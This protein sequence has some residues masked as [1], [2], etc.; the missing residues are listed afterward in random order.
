LGV[1]DADRM[2]RFAAVRLEDEAGH[3]QEIAA[4]DILEETPVE[5]SPRSEVPSI[6]PLS[7]DAVPAPQESTFKITVS[8]KRRLRAVVLWAMCLSLT[9]LAVAAL[10][11]TRSSPSSEPS[12]AAAAA[13][14]AAATPS[15]GEN[16]PTPSESPVAPSSGSSAAWVT[17]SQ[18]VASRSGT[19]TLTGAGLPL[20]IDGKRMTATSAIVSC[21]PH[22]IR[23]G[24]NKLRQVVVPCGATV[25]LDRAGTPTVR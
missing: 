9:I 13:A 14:A 11:Q 15:P 8:P 18:P 17:T 19:I 25:L 23:V 4:A 6:W 21:G 10:S 20:F 1:G 5:A 24:R 22:G 16:P 2:M 12:M 7:F 3:T